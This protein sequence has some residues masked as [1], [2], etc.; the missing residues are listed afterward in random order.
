MRLLN[1]YDFDGVD[2]AWQFPPVQVK[3]HRSSLG[4]F[5]QGVKKVFGYGK[6][7]D[8]KEEEHRNGF[9]NL[10]R[11]LKAQLRSR[12]KAV[13]LTI[14]PHVNGSGKPYIHRINEVTNHFSLI[15]I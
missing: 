2:L 1:E 5:W 14:L 7:K 3:K 11:D 9:T 13:T 4:N 12:N 15:F 8:T 6:F 10:V